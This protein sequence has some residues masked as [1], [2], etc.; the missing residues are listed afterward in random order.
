MLK[1]CGAFSLI[2]F[3]RQ[4]FLTFSQI[5]EKSISV[6]YLIATHPQA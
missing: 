1:T 5:T 4:Q 6:L 3:G 2:S